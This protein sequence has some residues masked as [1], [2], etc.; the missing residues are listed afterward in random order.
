MALPPVHSPFPP[1]AS[2]RYIRTIHLECTEDEI[3]ALN[4]LIRPLQA[5]PGRPFRFDSLPEKTRTVLE[6]FY[7]TIP[8]TGF[9]VTVPDGVET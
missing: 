7:G 1:M 6:N 4:D 5:N 9:F 3:R 2:F 8:G